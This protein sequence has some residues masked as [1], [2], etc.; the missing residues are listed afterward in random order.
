MQEG[1]WL[2]ARR[3]GFNPRGGEVEFSL[4]HVQIDS[5]V[6]LISYKLSRL[7]VFFR[8]TDGRAMVSHPASS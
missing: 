7:L 3:P 6:Y 5:K 1:A 8:S 4:L 2:L